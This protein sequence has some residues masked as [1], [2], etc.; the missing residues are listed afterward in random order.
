MKGTYDYSFRSK[1]L[2][3]VKEF[4]DEEFMIIG[5]ECDTTSNKLIGE[6]FVFVLENN[7]SLLQSDTTANNTFKA[8][9]MG[10]LEDKLNF[11]SNIEKLKGKMATVR[12]QERSNDGIPIQGHVRKE[13]KVLVQ[14]IR[15]QGE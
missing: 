15:P 5:C 7:R 12:F 4:L 14:H 11:Y 6:S 9:P 13:S 10:T 1:S 2:L 8:R 3:K